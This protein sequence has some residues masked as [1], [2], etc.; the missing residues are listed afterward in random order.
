MKTMIAAALAVL[1]AC[2]VGAQNLR[3]CADRDL[4]VERLAQK[5]GETR[6]ALGLGGQGAMM[7]IFASEASGSWTI[8]ITTPNGSTCL[9]ATGQNYEAFSEPLPPAGDDL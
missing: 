3:H 5:Y 1:L 6:Q 8:T 9:M 7:E 2:P 4:V